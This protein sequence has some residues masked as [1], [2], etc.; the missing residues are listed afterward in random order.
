MFLRFQH[1]FL[2]PPVVWEKPWPFPRPRDL[3]PAE[4]FPRNSLC[5][6]TAL[7]IQFTLASLRI[8]YKNM[9]HLL[10]KIIKPL[11]VCYIYNVITYWVCSI[12]CDDFV[13]FEGRVLSYPVWV[14][15]TKATTT[16]SN[17]FLLLQKRTKNNIKN[18]SKYV[19]KMFNQY[20]LLIYYNS[21]S[22]GNK[23]Y[24]CP[25]EKNSAIITKHNLSSLLQ[26]QLTNIQGY[27][28]EYIF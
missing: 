9:I 22:Q 3:R 27:N 23:M 10:R 20:N 8:A 18:M 12:N 25:H 19:G 14:K 7:Q 15:D 16:T 11:I 13:E 17:S 21:D 2:D 1:A 24:F 4:V 6:C 5:L 28:I 26:L